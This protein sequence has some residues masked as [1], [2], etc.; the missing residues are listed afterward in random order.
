MP[1]PKLWLNPLRPRVK[2]DSQ[3]VPW[4]IHSNDKEDDILWDSYDLIR[5]KKKQEE[6]QVGFEDALDEGAQDILRG[7]D[8]EYVSTLT[9]LSRIFTPR[10]TES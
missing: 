10:L 3:E 4:E 2:G 5:V 9:Y 1:G 6:E 8:T 7:K